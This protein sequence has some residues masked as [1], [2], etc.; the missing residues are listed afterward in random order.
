MIQV[1][2]ILITGANGYLG[3]Q[4]SRH[5]ALQGHSITALCYPEAPK[6]EEWCELMDEVL[7]GNVSERKT[8][9]GLSRRTFDTIIHL[10]SMDHHQS[11]AVAPEKAA[12][13]NVQPCWM[14]LD[15]FK[16]R[17][18][19]TFLYFSTIHVYG[20][21]PNISITEQQPLNPG[22]VY[23]LTHALCEQICDYYNRTTAIN[24][25]TVRLSNSF[26]HPVFSE[27]NCWWLA[28]NDLCR[29][30]FLEKKIKLLSDGSPVRDFIHGSDVCQAV[31]LLCEKAPK[32]TARNTY[33]ISSSKTYTLLEL[34]G[35]VREE[36]EEMY[37]EIIPVSTPVEENVTDFEKFSRIDR[38]R[39]D[40]AALQALGFASKCDIREGIRR[41][42]IYFEKNSPYA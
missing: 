25:L 21:L 14:L 12:S 8:I 34:A 2:K 16:E 24:C 36:Y 17:G 26:G 18:L 5:L 39:I 40:N 23:A 32:T 11:Q 19:K 28:V 6:D 30:A 38:Y 37:G 9:D 35:I 22:N 41:L 15:A 20:A 27:N 13:V 29:T 10:V 3:A 1:Q 42:F 31:E 7:V 33:H 4:L